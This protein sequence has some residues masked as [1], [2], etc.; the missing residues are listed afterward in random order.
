MW[1]YT[2]AAQEYKNVKAKEL[3]LRA[4]CIDPD[5]DYHTPNPSQNK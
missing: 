1:H 5:Q 2:S 4:S 3:V